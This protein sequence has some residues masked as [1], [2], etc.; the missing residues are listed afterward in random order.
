MAK[1]RKSEKAFTLVE[2]LCVVALLGMI[3]LIALPAAAD[4]GRSRSAEL[5]A[6]SMALD[7]RKTQQKAITAGWTQR[8]EFRRYNDDYLI[9][10]G[11]TSERVRI[12]LPE[13]VTY[14]S[15]N[16]PV[17]GSNRL[18]SF[19]RT[20]APNSGGTVTLVNTAGQVYYV[21]VTPATGRVRISATP[22]DHW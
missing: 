12:S 1:G 5:V 8:I 15:I 6:R 20:G 19:N 11:K 17:S 10:D 21:I 18:L 2:M 3:M 22:P 7:M 13:G 14:Q 16:F 4:L 9:I